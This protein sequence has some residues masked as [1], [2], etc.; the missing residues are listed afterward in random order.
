MIIS[1]IVAAT[2]NNVIG[3]DGDLP[4]KLPKD[5]RF[6]RETTMGHHVVMGRKNWDS[7][8]EKYRPLPGRTNL[9]VTRNTAL[10]LDGAHVCGSIESALEMAKAQGD[11]EAFVIGGGQVYAHS[12]EQDLLQ[13]V[14]LTRIHATID[15]DVQFPV[16]DESTWIMRTQTFYPA[17]EKHEFAFSIQVWEK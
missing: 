8:P 9:V 4:W 16:F 2:E 5:M 11:D 3:K 1:A 12:F 7:I 6:F 10:T 14:Y 17:D 13:R 15:G